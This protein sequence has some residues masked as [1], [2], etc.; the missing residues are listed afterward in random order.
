MDWNIK[1]ES[2]ISNKGNPYRIKQFMYRAQQNEALT[3][4]FIG[5]SVTQGSLASRPGF[6]YAARVVSW[7]EQ[8][9]PGAS[10]TYINAGIG[11]TTSQF[12]CARV[13]EDVLDAQPDLVFVEFSVND[14]STSLFLE[15]YEGLV[16]RILYAPSAPAVMLVHNV[17]FDNGANAQVQ[18]AKIAR[19]YQIPSVSMQS[20]LYPQVVNGEI[21]LEAITPDGLHPNDEGHRL[22]ASVITYFLQEIFQ[23][24]E[25]REGEG[26]V[27]V[28]PP[29]TEGCYGSA[30][31]IQNNNWPDDGTKQPVLVQTEGFAADTSPKQGFTDVFKNGWIAAHPGDTIRFYA[32]T[33]EL[34][35]QYRRSVRKPAPCAKVFI[36]GKE[37]ALL[38]GNFEESW[39]DCLF[40]LPVLHHGERGAHKV[41]IEIVESAEKGETPF[42]LLGL[43][44]A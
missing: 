32:E 33:S 35:V 42:Y 43:I 17:R 21:P 16:R 3:V 40:L 2:G 44:I 37:A 10:F 7:L 11:G 31:R 18:H 29:V 30:V 12:A 1:K 27:Q 6:C 5:G 36:D 9:F 19:Y 15:T 26:P 20:C 34:A 4:A 38:D 13:Q 25:N 41:E 14:S 28:L 23:E 39:G 8:M 24:G 22:V